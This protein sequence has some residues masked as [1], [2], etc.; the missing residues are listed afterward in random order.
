MNFY[1]R[2]M[3]N[4]PPDAPVGGFALV[5]TLAIMALLAIVM[6]GMLSLS[7]ISVRSSRSD[8]YETE[9][10]ANARL[11]LSLA[12]GELQKQLG[13]D[14]RVSATASLLDS[15]AETRKPEG[16]RHPHWVGVWSHLDAE[17]N[18]V[19]ER[20]EKNG[21]LLDR[22]A[23][24]DWK[25]EQEAISYLV[26]GNEGGRGRAFKFR[27]AA[28]EELDDAVTL[29][30]KGSLGDVP[31]RVEDGQV[32][33]ARVPV[34]SRK[35]GHYAYWVG[36]LG[37]RANIATRNPYDDGAGGELAEVFDLMVAQETQ[38]GLMQ[39]GDTS[40]PPLA[41]PQKGALVT[42]GQ[43]DL[44]SDA[45]AD[46]RGAHFHDVTTASRSV[47]ADVRFGG[48]KRDLT[49]YF[50]SD[51]SIDSLGTPGAPGIDDQ[52]NIV[53]PPNE[54]VAA[55]RD[56]AW[57]ESG[58]RFT[59]PRFGLLRRWARLADQTP[60]GEAELTASY[61]KTEPRPRSIDLQGWASSNLQPAS[62]ASLDQPSLAPILVEGSM[63]S[64]VSWHRNPPGAAY[65]FNI[66][67]HSYPR[68]V[69]W[70]P[71][72]V[73]LDVKDL[74]VLLHVNGRKEMHTDGVLVNPTTRREVGV[75]QDIHWIW[76]VGGRSSELLPGQD[77]LQS[78]LYKDP[79]IGSFY[80]SLA[81]TK[82]GPGETLMFT[83]DKA[84]EYNHGALEENTLSAKVAPD[85]DR[86]YYFTASELDGGMNFYPTSYWF[87]PT[88]RNIRNQSDDFRM[89]LKHR[90]SR[91]GI[92]AE[93]FDALPQVAYVSC[94][95]QY[96]AGREPRLAWNA[97][98]RESMFETDL[99][100]A[101][102]LPRPGQP[103]KPVP[104]VRTRD[105]YRLRWF[106][107]H[108]SNLEASGALQGEPHF[109]TAHLA[110]WNPR[111]AYS[112]RTPWDNL[113]GQVAAD[114]SGSGPWFFGNYTRDLF[115][116]AVSWLDLMPIP[117]DGKY[118]GNPFGQPLEGRHRNILFDVP[119]YGTEVM[120]LGQLQ[121]A[122]LSEFSW[123]P[124]YAI[125]QSLIDPRVGASSSA[126]QF[127][128]VQ[129]TAVT[130]WNPANIGWSEDGQRGGDR[131]TWA[132]FARALAQ[133]YAETDALVYDLS[134]EANYSLWDS[135]FLSTGTETQKRQFAADPAR[136]PLPNA[137]FALAPSTRD[138]V[139]PERLGDFHRAA[140][141]LMVEGGFNVNSTSEEA[142]KAVLAATRDN[143]IASPERTA[144]PRVVNA[145]EG[146]ADGGEANEDAAWG[147]FRSLSDEDLDKLATA[148]VREV[149]RR[150]PFL[151]LADFVNRRLVADPADPGG[152]R[153][154]LQAA[155]EAA[156]LNDDF[157]LAYPL[158]NSLPLSDYTHPDHVE[159]PTRLEQ[160][161]KPAS[162]AWGAP[163]YLTQ[164][165]LLQVLGPV[166]NA[167]SDTFVIRAYGD[168]VDR[169]GAVRARAW[170]EAVVQRTPVPV[171]ASATGLN[172]ANSGKKGDFG[173]RFAIQS[174][175]WL[176]PGEI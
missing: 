92:R 120:S 125:G 4:S 56:I 150:G 57:T 12:L 6:L 2:G 50:L 26:S 131:E 121:H 112:F 148:I 124:T 176:S 42:A 43:V 60:H 88:V 29:V 58:H 116:Q 175:R 87:A 90:G 123:H 25:R 138:S 151:S 164:G 162:M 70:N 45:A 44:L 166:I 61:P 65:L 172:P 169:E 39:A 67:L 174:F 77:I 106:N 103:A 156:G 160:T 173:R 80:F 37:V 71:Y 5:T 11:A 76:F 163:G 108:L 34:D 115:D 15:R 133:D 126:P 140:Y 167:R 168:A 102:W 153:G 97:E 53:G 154:A 134:Y 158:D 1:G 137:R 41:E 22:R 99:T 165:D 110:N 91:R 23:H 79:Y 27:D 73:E 3:R 31:E 171:E 59:S 28:T 54:E 17:G 7:S 95:M 109:E 36:D 104:N 86:N 19:W 89:I 33:V 101:D 96:G 111:A 20:E 129:E 32:R 127:D 84:A 30:G 75:F 157:Q 81:D 100:S 82:I 132:E 128:T 14:Q 52:D 142:W 35:D 149:K 83:P 105:G 139:S 130:G 113:A 93:D 78:K 143:A 62:I 8:A 49:A 118:H 10:K 85:A 46:W 64:V 47:L 74:M 69:L 40:L 136:H 13:P 159:D 119:R 135:Y 170:C 152:R 122:K 161:L 144:F 107:E 155:I 9:A 145:P 51:G 66:R 38:P 147:G 141:H 55:Q 18:S 114:G 146:E 16:V 68:V 48:L 24:E 98:M 21:G 72:N 63:Y 94:S 117:R